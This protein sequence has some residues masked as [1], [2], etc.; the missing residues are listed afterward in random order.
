MVGNAYDALTALNEYRDRSGMFH[1]GEGCSRS[2][3]LINGVVY[4]ISNNCA[5]GGENSEEYLRANIMRPNL[6]QGFAIPD[7]TLFTVEDEEILACEYIDGI[8]T[9][10]CSDAWLGLPCSCGGT[11]LS[12]QTMALIDNVIDF[13]DWSYG[14]VI[15]CEGVLYLIDCV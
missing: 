2:A 15:D 13:Y 11:C 3:Y 5:S 12:D 1:I 4:K 14:N 9:G 7:M 8:L 10:E 6:P